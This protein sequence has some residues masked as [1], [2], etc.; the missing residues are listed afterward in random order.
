MDEL[1]PGQV[2][3]ITATDPGFKMD[4]GAW[5]DSTGNSLI[6]V[7]SDKGVITALVRKGGV[8]EQAE[9]NPPPASRDGKTIIVFSNDLDKVMA[10]FI[11]ANGAASMGGRV[12]M[13][14]TF[15]GLNVLRRQEPGPVK[16][17]VIESM[18]GAMM[19][20]GADQLTLSKMHM[21]GMGT[22]MMK[23]VMK[24]KNVEGLSALIKSAQQAGVR[25]VACTMTMDIMGIKREELIDGVEEGGV[26]TYLSVADKAGLNLF[27]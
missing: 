23:Y 24:N 15:W 12:T 9:G 17:D 11:I 20:Q 13:F 1:S 27:I 18:F 6:S 21:G 5:C 4:V 22:A 25:L 2:L 26:A 8:Q 16:K 14:F 7:T 10:S 19:P 3:K